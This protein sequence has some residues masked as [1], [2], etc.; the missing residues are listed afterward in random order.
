M[1]L[2]YTDSNQY[3]HEQMNINYIATKESGSQRFACSTSYTAMT[4]LK[5]NIFIVHIGYTGN[6][7]S[8][9]KWLNI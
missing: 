1:W 5:L 7:T 8:N 2:L 4:F 6:I 9:T 3:H